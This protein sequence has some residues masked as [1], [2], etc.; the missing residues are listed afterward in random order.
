MIEITLLRRWQRSVYQ[1]KAD[2]KKE[3]D[4]F[5][6]QTIKI[7]MHN[8]NIIFCLTCVDFW[9]S[10]MCFPLLVRLSFQV[11]F[12]MWTVIVCVH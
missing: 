1:S 12:H 2:D 8:A 6:R 5:Q 11:I 4:L 3:L 9:Y 10:M 7:I